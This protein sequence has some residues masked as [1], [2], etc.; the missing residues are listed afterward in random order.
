MSVSQSLY[1]W[2]MCGAVGAGDDVSKREA[3]LTDAVNKIVA[4]PKVG[5]V[6]HHHIIPYHTPP[7]PSL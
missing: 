4:G 7:P 3:A 2:V 6:N 5:K 1:E